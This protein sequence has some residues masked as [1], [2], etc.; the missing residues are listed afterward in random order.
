MISQRFAADKCD[1]IGH[2]LKEEFERNLLKLID[3]SQPMEVIDA[4]ASP[5][6]DQFFRELDA[7]LNVY[8]QDYEDDC[9]DAEITIQKRNCLTRLV[10]IQLENYTL[11]K[12][13]TMES[14]DDIDAA[15]SEKLAWHYAIKKKIRKFYSGN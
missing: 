11:E 10:E 7:V 13:R 9:D 12:L 4:T 1:L 6:I 15:I 14:L 8:G 5:M 2:L 3:F